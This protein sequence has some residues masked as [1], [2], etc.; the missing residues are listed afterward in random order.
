MTAEKIS[1]TFEQVLE[2][3]RCPVDVTCIWA[4]LFEAKRTFGPLI[5]S[6]LWVSWVQGLFP[7][8]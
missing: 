6:P 1:V 7:L 2:D 4:G 3:S 8:S 5:L